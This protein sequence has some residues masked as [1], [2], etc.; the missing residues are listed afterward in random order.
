MG[1]GGQKMRK[2]RDATGLM[3]EKLV[4]EGGGSAA[5]GEGT[6]LLET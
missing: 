4:E 3:K 2:R 1:V 5:S 6:L